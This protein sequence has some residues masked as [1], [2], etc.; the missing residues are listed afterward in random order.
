MNL[1]FL[2]T[3]TGGLDPKKNSLLQIGLVAYVDGSI[4]N[5][6]E[7]S[8]KEDIYNINAYAMKYNG[9]D[10]YE[11][12]YKGGV[13]PECALKLLTDFIADNFVEEIPILVGHNPSI[14]KYMIKELFSRCN[15]D[16]NDYISHRMI[17]T[18]S[19]IWGLHFAGKLPIKACSSNGAFKYFNIVPKKRHHALDDSLA[20]VKLF[21]NLLRLL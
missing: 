21:E 7:F 8:I 3:E 19:I 17:D 13:S 16:M 4:K 20:T 12:I 15:K 2:D 1:L 14:D 5:T 9:L 11:D 6:K 18:M 10:L